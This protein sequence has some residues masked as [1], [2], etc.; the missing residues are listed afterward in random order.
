MTAVMSERIL[1]LDFDLACGCG[2]GRDCATFVEQWA[3]FWQRQTADGQPV[4]VIPCEDYIDRL[5]ANGRKSARRGLRRY[6]IGEFDVNANR[7]GIDAIHRSKTE[8]SQ[9][10]LLTRWYRR[11]VSVQPALSLCEV[12]KLTWYGAFDAS[13]TLRAYWSIA[14]LGRLGTSVWLFRH[15]DHSDYALNGLAAH[16]A[17]NAGVDFVSYHTMNAEP[18]TGRPE[19][20][21]RIGCVEA[22]L[23]FED[24][25]S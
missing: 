16:I 24:V 6:S 20:K 17:E 11:P 25:T 22:R 18:H 13:G 10:P 14:M 5:S 7:T 3:Q 15:A 12:H 4:A 1:T 8:T 9:G 21:R 23:T 2:E 19:F